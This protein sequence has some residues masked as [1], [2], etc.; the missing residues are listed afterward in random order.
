MGYGYSSSNSSTRNTTLNTFELLEA[1]IKR[2]RHNLATLENETTAQYD[3]QSHDEII[4][5]H[6]NTR[7]LI[8]Y[9]DGRISMS[10]SDEC[11][12]TVTKD[13]MWRYAGVNICRHKLPIVNG[14]LPSPT[15]K[16]FF[17]IERSLW[18]AYN[19]VGRIMINVDRT[20]DEKTIKP[21]DITVIAKP[22]VLSALVRKGQKIYQQCRIRSRLG[23]VTDA[24]ISVFSLLPWLAN[25]VDLPLDEVDYQTMPNLP[26]MYQKRVR[27]PTL[28]QH[29]KGSYLRS[30]FTEV[31]QVSHV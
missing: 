9:R 29:I 26:E 8:F 16:C 20:V 6:Y 15:H 2:S 24:N 27:L 12:S 23:I 28:A 22:K 3:S 25:R 11:L 30:R 5:T 21:Y 18:Y 7:I 31:Q 14:R 19:S 17:Q 4:I 10:T 1:A 13:R